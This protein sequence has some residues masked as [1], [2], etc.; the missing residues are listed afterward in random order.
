MDNMGGNRII[1]ISMEVFD[2]APQ[3]PG[4]APCDV[5]PHDTIAESGYNTTRLSFSSHHGTHLDA[6]FHFLSD[7]FGVDRI[8][9]TKCVGPAVIIDMSHKEPRALIDVDDLSPHAHRITKGSRVVIRTGWDRVYPDTKYFSDFP[10]ITLKAATWL[11]EREIALLGMD[12]PTPNG[13]SDE[14]VTEVHK[15]LLQAEVVIL[16]W[17]ASLDQIPGDTFFLIAAPLKI[18]GCDGSPLR[19]LAIV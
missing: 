14:A 15:V 3:F 7:G 5:K 1:D 8:D 16:E 6:P 18:R 19:A 10:S 17:L 2:G 9:L 13:E 11:A 4:D 12:M